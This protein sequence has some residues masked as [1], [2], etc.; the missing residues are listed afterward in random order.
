MVAE[1]RYAR[2]LSERKTEEAETAL[3]RAEEAVGQTSSITI[4]ALPIQSYGTP[5]SSPDIST[6]SNSQSS[7]NTHFAAEAGVIL[8]YGRHVRY[9]HSCAT[10]QANLSSYHHGILGYGFSIRRESG[11]YPPPL[12]QQ[13][14]QE[15]EPKALRRNQS[16]QRTHP[17]V[18]AAHRSAPARAASLP[19]TETAV[20]SMLLRLPF[21]GEAK[22]AAVPSLPPH[23]PEPASSSA[24]ETSKQT[25]PSSSPAP[26][27]TTSSST[28]YYHNSPPIPLRAGYKRHSSTLPNGIPLPDSR[29]GTPAPVVYGIGS[30]PVPGAPP[31]IPR[32]AAARGASR[33]GSNVASEPISRLARRLSTRC[34]LQ[35]PEVEKMPESN[36]DCPPSGAVPATQTES[37][38]GHLLKENDMEG[39]INDREAGALDQTANKRTM[40]RMECKPMGILPRTVAKKIHQMRLT[41]LCTEAASP[42]PFSPTGTDVNV[43]S[44]PEQQDP[45]EK[46]EDKE[47]YVGDVT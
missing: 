25:P 27:V 20:G 11:D 14:S 3:K 2:H 40:K 23:S 22:V 43:T 36:V 47:I 39:A 41:G 16:Y 21:L 1:A 44:D 45:E 29:P 33:L 19:T 12:K 15:T 26:I 37:S 32:W 8:G 5:P 18:V 35:P 42:S 30:S 38:S 6:S 34:T 7:A 46:G 4:P 9:G 24:P 17:A 13:L 28:S 31:P 10:R